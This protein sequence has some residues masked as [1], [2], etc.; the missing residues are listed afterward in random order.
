MPFLNDNARC[1]HF[2]S[3]VLFQPMSFYSGS[4]VF[5]LLRN[6]LSRSTCVGLQLPQSKF[7]SP[8]SRRPNFTDNASDIR[9]L[10]INVA[11]GKRPAKS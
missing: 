3:Y 9:T 11:S 8:D 10:Y 4:S 7:Q 6:V 2:N 1:H 5:S